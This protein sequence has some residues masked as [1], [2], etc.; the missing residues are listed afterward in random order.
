MHLHVTGKNDAYVTLSI[1]DN[2][3]GRKASEQLKKNRVL[4]RNSVGIDITKERLANFSKSYEN[5]FRLEIE[6]LY[7]NEGNPSG[8]RVRLFLPTR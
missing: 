7:D 2:G 4:K 8:T 5:S 6:D 1:T 3:V